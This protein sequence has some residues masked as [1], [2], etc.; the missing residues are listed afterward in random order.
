MDELDEFNEAPHSL[1]SETNS[2]NDIRSDD[3]ERI[4]LDEEDDDDDEQNQINILDRTTPG[5]IETNDLFGATDLLSSNLTDVDLLIDDKNQ[6]HQTKT[7]SVAYLLNINGDVN[8]QRINNDVQQNILNDNISSSSSNSSIMFSKSDKQLNTTN[9]L[10]NT[11]IVD[12]IFIQTS[13]TKNYNNSF[14]SNSR[15]A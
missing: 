10:E 3:M 9:A 14:S 11:A 15:N 7:Q 5:R 12:D 1:R 6:Y 4:D 8:K 2:F 13:K